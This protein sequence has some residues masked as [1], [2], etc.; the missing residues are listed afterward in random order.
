VRREKL[1]AL[2]PDWVFERMEDIA[3]TLI[4]AA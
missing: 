2:S 4:P 3:S 1:R